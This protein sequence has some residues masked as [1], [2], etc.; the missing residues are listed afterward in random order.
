M[1][2]VRPATSSHV[3][4]DVSVSVKMI[5]ASSYFCGV[6]DHVPLALGEPADASR[7]RLNHSCSEE[8]WFITRSTM[9]RSPRSWA[10][11]MKADVVDLP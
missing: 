2:V 10:A 8:V 9:T 4:F 11:S 1:P 7:A 5:R 3:Q 6:S